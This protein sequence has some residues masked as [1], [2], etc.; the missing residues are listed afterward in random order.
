[1]ESVQDGQTVLTVVHAEHVR[2]VAMINE[3]QQNAPVLK[4][5]RTYTNSFCQF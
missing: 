1:M 3:E 4:R 5:K 2:L